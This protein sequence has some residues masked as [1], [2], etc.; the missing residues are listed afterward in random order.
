MIPAY[1]DPD[2]PSNVIRPR[3][4]CWGCGKRGCVGKRWGNWCFICNVARIER[5]SARMGFPLSELR[6]FPAER[7]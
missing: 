3:V 2:H 6:I 5:I 1:K 4:R 7:K